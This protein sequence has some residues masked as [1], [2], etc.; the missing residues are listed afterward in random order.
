MNNTKQKW[1]SDLIKLDPCPEAVEW[2][3]SYESPDDAWAKCKR[4]DWMLWVAGRLSED[5]N[6][7]S[8]KKLVLAACKCARLALP[9]VRPGETR[10]RAAIDLTERWA[11]GDQSVTL[12]MVGGAARA[13]WDAGAAMAAWD[14]ARAAG[15]AT[16][17]AAW[18]AMAAWDVW[19]APAAGDAMAAGGA[20]RSQGPDLVRVFDP[21]PPPKSPSPPGRR[22]GTIN[23]QDEIKELKRQNK[24]LTTA[25][26]NLTLAT[27]IF[28][29]RLDETMKL[30]SD[31]DR[32]KTITT[33][34]NRLEYE[35][36]KVR[37]FALGV[38]YRHDPE[39]T[40]SNQRI[41]PK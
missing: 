16:W 9:Y 22:G 14:A 30:S 17:A 40:A 4:G 6:S 27:G 1:L 29:R 8:R 13:A 5:A 2:A 18:A 21:S 19:D 10:P 28:L 37:Y 15:D 12:E 35:R 26:K 3:K 38:D 33:L 31:N 7:A 25:L 32:G 20:A 23:M 41:M 24:A 11:N 36:D 34:S 39:I